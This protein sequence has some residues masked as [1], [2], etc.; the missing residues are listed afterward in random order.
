MKKSNTITLELTLYGLIFLA[1]LAL[2][3]FQLGWNPLLESEASWALQAWQLAQN[4]L[5]PV[6]SQVAYLSFSEVL[7]TLFGSG[8]FLARVWPALVGSILVWLPYLFRNDLG[9]IPAL[10]IAGGLALDPTLVP[11]S[12]FAGSLMPALVFLA[13]AL[14]TFH[15]R[16]ISWFLVFLVLGLLSGPA[17]WMG[18]FILGI[19]ILLSSLLGLLKPADYFGKRMEIF[20]GKPQDWLPVGTPALLIFL[21]TG[22][23]FL[24]EIEGLSAWA[25]ALPEFIRSWGGPA[26]YGMGKLLVYFLLNNPLI[27]VF[28]LGG[29]LTAWRVKDPVGQV[30][31][32]WFA[33]SLVGLTIYP[34]RGAAD[35][36]WLAIPL[37][38]AAAVE[39]IRITRLASSTWITRVMS[40]IVVVLATLNWLTLI[41]MI[42]QGANE[43]ALLLELGLLLA[44]LALI[45]LSAAIISSEWGWF[46]ARKGLVDG[47]AAALLLYL[48][49]SLSLDT[50]LV[51]HDPRSI[52]SEGTGAGQMELL[53]NS[54][55]DVSITATGRPDSIQG[56]VVSD[57]QALR[58]TL[59]QFE[60][61]DFLVNP[62]PGIEYPIVITTGVTEPPVLQE[63]YRGQDFVLA[64]HPGWGR[65]LPDDWISWIGFRKGPLAND[66]LILWVRNDI[67]S[68][69]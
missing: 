66:Y 9:R 48:I 13:L 45:I 28:G 22:S 4:E 10:I 25:G 31:S 16:K 67:Y 1:A 59:R 41:G 29:F 5:I 51:S 54:V 39:F 23:F 18:I 21:I 36:A 57:N 65:I 14:G 46:T 44:S 11:V 6:G 24:R 20:K 35:L 15:T 30:L 62:P 60:A 17:F 50:Y 61:I 27:L 52:F 8:N 19:V 12:R 33:V 43:N 37:W 58:W 47:A 40:G 38:V 3:L 7:F 56:A 63:N 34:G 69:Y 53:E 64:T 42:F 32:L 26:E 55:A 49:A 2:R 68:G